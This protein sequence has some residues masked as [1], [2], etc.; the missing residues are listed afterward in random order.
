[1]MSNRKRW[2][3]I[4]FWPISEVH[5]LHKRERSL[6]LS[7]TKDRT[8]PTEDHMYLEEQN[9]RYFPQGFWPQGLTEDEK[10]TR[11]DHYFAQI[12]PV[13]AP[14]YEKWWRSCSKQGGKTEQETMEQIELAIH[15]CGLRPD[16]VNSGDADTGARRNALGS[17]FKGVL[18]G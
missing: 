14:I 11:L 4:V 1:M 18:G 15:S 8:A 9:R 16:N 17:K 5:E 12:Y 7:W 6:C 3:V 10:R 2:A 13:W